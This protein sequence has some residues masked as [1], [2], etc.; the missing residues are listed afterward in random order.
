MMVLVDSCVAFPPLDRRHVP[1]S[2]RRMGCHGVGLY[3]SNGKHTYIST[4]LVSDEVADDL[5]VCMRRSA[6]LKSSVV[7]SSRPLS[8]GFDPCSLPADGPLLTPDQT[9]VPDLT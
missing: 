5:E 3:G 4:K 8:I 2:T 7:P 6:E 9:L 1:T